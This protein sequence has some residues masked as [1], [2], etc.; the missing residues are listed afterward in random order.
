MPAGDTIHIEV[1]TAE[2]ELYS[3]EANAVNAQAP[4]DV[5]ASC[6][7]TLPCSPFLKQASYGSN[8]KGPKIRSSSQVV[9]LKSTKIP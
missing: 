7:I 5:W 6:R 8:C 2:H 3:G 1:V 9:S 4:K